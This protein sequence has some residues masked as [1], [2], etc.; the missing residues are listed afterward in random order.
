MWNKQ[1]LSVKQNQ[2]LIEFKHTKLK[3]KRPKWMSN[4]DVQQDYL[5]KKELIWLLF[6]FLS[7]FP[8]RKTSVLYSWFII[9]KFE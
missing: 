7:F 8:G 3:F 9:R 4:V 5:W 6:R 2:S 1:P